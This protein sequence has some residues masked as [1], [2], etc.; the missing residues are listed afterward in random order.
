MLNIHRETEKSAP[1]LLSNV[2]VPK[3]LGR[4]CLERGSRLPGIQRQPS[5]AAG[6]LPKGRAGPMGLPRKPGKQKGAIPRP[7][8]NQA[9]STQLPIHRPESVA[10]G[11]GTWGHLPVLGLVWT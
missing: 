3:H 10:W 2:C 6:F 7:A 4:K 9:V 11:Q 8:H 1:V 5:F